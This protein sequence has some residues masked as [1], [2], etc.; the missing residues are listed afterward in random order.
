LTLR[1][2]TAQRTASRLNA[3]KAQLESFD[4]APNFF[5]P[6]GTISHGPAYGRMSRIEAYRDYGWECLALAKSLAGERERRALIE[7]AAV[8]HELAEALSRFEDEH[9]GQSRHAFSLYF[10]RLRAELVKEM[11]DAFERGSLW[12]ALLLRLSRSASATRTLE[13]AAPPP[14]QSSRYATW[15]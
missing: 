13:F 6:S 4:D 9:D 7:M 15:A 14:R 8:W 10:G 11:S 3:S 12:R 2:A 5:D 1:L